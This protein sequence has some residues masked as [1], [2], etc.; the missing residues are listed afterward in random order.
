MLRVARPTS[1]S[2]ATFFGLNFSLL[3]CGLVGSLVLLTSNSPYDQPT[4]ERG[5]GCKERQPSLVDVRSFG[6]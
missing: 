6:L 5:H 3:G 4:R 2:D 1:S